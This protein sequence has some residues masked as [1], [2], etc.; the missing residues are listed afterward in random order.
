MLTY[1][2]QVTVH[3]TL[4]HNRGNWCGKVSR[5]TDLFTDL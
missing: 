5:V 1:D 4:T 3:S 2:T